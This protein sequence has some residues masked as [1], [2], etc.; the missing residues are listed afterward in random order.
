MPSEHAEPALTVRAPAELK[1]AAQDVLNDRG[2]EMRSFIVACLTGLR[3]DPDGLL[4]V[5][6]RHWPAPKPRRGGRPPRSS[7]S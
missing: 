3:E 5:L 7:P 4:D 1:S 2:L 6:A